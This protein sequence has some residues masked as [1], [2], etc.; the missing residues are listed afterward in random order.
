MSK[1]QFHFWVY[2]HVFRPNFFSEEFF[3]FV[4]SLSLS[5][6]LPLKLF[7]SE[8]LTELYLLLV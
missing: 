3:N 5:L 2:L 6:S 8:E 7:S 4:V 1:Q